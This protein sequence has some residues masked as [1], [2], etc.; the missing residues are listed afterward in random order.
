MSEAEKNGQGKKS[1]KNKLSVI[2]AVV[3]IATLALSI[4]IILEDAVTSSRTRSIAYKLVCGNHLSAL[5][6]AMFLYANDWDDKFPPAD[7]W[8]DYLVKYGYAKEKD[9]KGHKKGRCNYAMNPNVKTAYAPPGLVLLFETGYR[10]DGNDWNQHGGPELLSFENH[11]GD[12]CNIVFTGGNI[13][14]IKAGNLSW[15]KW[16][17]EPNEPN[18]IK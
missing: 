9:F 10:S 18:E 14:F 2:L 16:K 5:A 6:K 12:G 15:L 8:C 3:L 1:Q 17:D 7:K 4:W 11:K 13:C